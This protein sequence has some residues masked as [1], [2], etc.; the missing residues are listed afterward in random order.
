MGKLIAS[1]VIL[2]MLVYVVGAFLRKDVP[3]RSSQPSESPHQA[4]FELK[5]NIGHVNIQK[6][7]FDMPVNKAEQE[8]TVIPDQD[9]FDFYSQEIETKK[10]P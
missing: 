10:E 1:L 2:L 5:D 9:P 4:V 6:N 7:Y 3:N 8:D